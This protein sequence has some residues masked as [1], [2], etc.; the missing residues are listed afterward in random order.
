[1]KKISSNY[2]LNINVKWELIKRITDV[3]L[4]LPLLVLLT[5]VILFS[6]FAIYCESPGN[7]FFTQLRV[8]KNGKLFTI[9]KIRSLYI[10]HFG[11]FPDQEEPNAYRITPIGKYLRRSKLDELP[12]LLNI[13][14]GDMSFVGPR[15]FVPY[16]FDFD[17]NARKNR[18][19]VK[20]GLTGIAQVSGSTKL[21]KAN[22]AWMDIWYINNFSLFLDVK[23]LIVTVAAI[24]KGDDNCYDPFNLHKKL[25]EN[26]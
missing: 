18:V 3:L 17:E 20:P 7:P 16:Q 9:Y 8:G 12:Q 25:P 10:H 24:F 23:I 4:S 13:L 19:S 15:P 21:G 6:A 14:L 5:P 11:I 2:F 22:I 1:M 26:N